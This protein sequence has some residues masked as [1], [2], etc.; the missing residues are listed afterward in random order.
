LAG[1]Y[2]LVG[3]AHPTADFQVSI[4]NKEK[5]DKHTYWLA[6]AA[7][8]L[9]I[10]P[11]FIILV[12]L[13][14]LRSMLLKDVY[15]IPPHV[16]QQID[17]TYGLAYFLWIVALLLA[18]SAKTSL[19]RESIR[20]RAAIVLS[21]LGLSTC[22][23]IAVKPNIFH[24]PV[25]ARV[26][27]TESVM[28]D[29]DIAINSYKVFNA[30]Y[31]NRLDQLTT[32]VSHIAVVPN[33]VMV[34]RR[35]DTRQYDY[36]TDGKSFWIVRSVGPNQKPDAD[37]NMLADIIRSGSLEE[38]QYGSHIYEPINGLESDGD[39]IMTGP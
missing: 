37:L 30:C 9:S 11:Y 34:W 1:G 12:V 24:A 25:R 32:P 8:V 17:F 23:F 19:P 16:E 36:H 21:L 15:W 18:A 29:L 14:L 35:S 20:R 26:A 13:P 33:D 5:T 3:T 28:R 4:M 27:H 31:P 2:Y 10:P 22:M 6:S 39:I 38:I 7:F